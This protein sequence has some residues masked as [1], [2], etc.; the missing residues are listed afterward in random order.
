VLAAGVETIHALAMIVWALGLPLLVWH[1]YKRLARAYMW[2]AIVFVT[3]SVASNLVLGECFLT[4]LA[5]HLWT[6]AGGFREKVPFTVLFTNTVAGIRPSTREAVIAWE[7]AI[8][9]TSIGTLWCWRK[10]RREKSDDVGNSRPR[11]RSRR[12][13]GVLS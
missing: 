7:V 5:R 12:T 3:S 1:R 8:L 9:A 6:A 13:H 11:S 10:T 2:F 4:T